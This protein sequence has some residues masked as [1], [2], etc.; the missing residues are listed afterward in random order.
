MRNRFVFI[1]LVPSL[2]VAIVVVLFIDSW[3]E[4][5]LEY[6]GEQI[7][8][9]RVEVDGLDVGLFP[10]AMGWDRL[11]VTDPSDTWTNLFETGRVQF[12]MD[13]GQLLRAKF[14]IETVRV[15]GFVL[16][17]VRS[18]DGRLA[19]PP[20]PLDAPG[21][22]TDAPFADQASAVL[23]PSASSAPVFD[24]GRLRQQLNLDSLTNPANLETYR[25][26]D[27]L[28]RQLAAAETEW[29][30][31]LAE[32]EST[33]ERVSAIETQARSIDVRSINSVESAQ[34]AFNTAQQTYDNA[35]SAVQDLDR[36]KTNL[37]QS[38]NGFSSSIRSIDDVARRDFARVVA[39]AKLPDVSMRGLAAIVLGGEILDRAHEYL[40]YV[41][42]ARETIPKY[43]PK[44]DPDQLRRSEGVIVH[45]PEESSYPKWWIKEVVL[46]GGTDST[47]DPAYFYA[48]GA[49]RNLTNDQRITREP[50]TVDL[51]ARKGD[52]TS[53]SFEASFD[54]REDVPHD[55]YRAE[56]SGIEVGEMSL[57][58]SAFLP[59][60]VSDAL[61]RAVISVDVP[62][63]AL[64]SSARV[65]F[66]AVRIQFD[67]EP[68]SAVERLTGDVLTGVRTFFVNLRL[69]KTA[70]AAIDVA[71]ETD[72]DDQLSNR[73]RS[74]IGAEVARLR[75]EIRQRVDAQIAAKRRE[76]EALYTKKRAEVQT[77]IV[78]LERDIRAKVA[79]VDGKKKELE[80]RIEQE[81]KKAEDAIKKRAGDAIKGIFKKND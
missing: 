18:S 12:S 74:V 13:A 32:V 21:A 35:R 28:K 24:L 11:R 53:A 23:R 22:G 30:S 46:S 48:S 40:G 72:L 41:D 14:I 36:R 73:A 52:R 17:T 38:V 6:A 37:T 29:R 71:F 66:S 16:G 4:S 63:F 27:S 65:E 58:S 64:E 5:G 62:G 81:K 44:P 76:I 59:S 1:V 70:G 51:R 31:T 49:V 42:L 15:D 33:R 2:V 61:A 50:I 7:V 75:N 54:R 67:R 25:L 43:T 3:V 10:I 77:R 60:R 19:E 45:F 20:P 9:A 55:R 57:G 47:R 8:G 26:V 79:F 56:V 39:A 68:S 78:S 80:D 69:W 34:R